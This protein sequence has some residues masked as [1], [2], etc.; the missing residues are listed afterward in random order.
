MKNS[1]STKYYPGVYND[2]AWKE[3]GLLQPLDDPRAWLRRTT[4]K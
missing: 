4:K 1:R 3:V 2:L